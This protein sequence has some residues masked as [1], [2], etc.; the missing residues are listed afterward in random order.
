MDGVRIGASGVGLLI[1]TA[2]LVV[3]GLPPFAFTATLGIV[4]AVFASAVGRPGAALLG[5]TGWALCTGFG[6]YDL[7][8]LTFAP[9]DLIRLAA[10]VACAVVLGRDRF[11]AQ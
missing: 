8:D 10:Y 3:V 2:A 5:L 4:T 11:P 1:V 6:V 7:G 9:A